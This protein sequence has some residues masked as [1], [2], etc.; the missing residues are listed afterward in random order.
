[1]E[2]RLAWVGGE[3]DRSS[4]SLRV[5]PG[6]M[7]EVKIGKESCKAEDAP[8]YY[9]AASLPEHIPRCVDVAQEKAYS[10]IL[11]CDDIISLYQGMN[12]EE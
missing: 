4:S 11:Q 7:S 9:L 5:H 1:M 8:C 6:K 3:Y 2:S 10:S 12:K